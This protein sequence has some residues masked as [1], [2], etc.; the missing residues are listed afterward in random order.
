MI[1]LKL[2]YEI[3]NFSGLLEVSEKNLP[4]GN[5]KG[6]YFFYNQSKELL[7][8]GKSKNCIRQRLRKHLFLK[9]DRIED[10]EKYENRLTLAKR[11][12]YKY[13]SFCEIESDLVEIVEIFLIK[14]FKPIF[15]CEYNNVCNMPDVELTK[16][17]IEMDHKSNNIYLNL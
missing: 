5:T 9:F 12:Y 4:K 10:F 16:Y 6:C 2:E 8:V 11:E 14:K 17:E 3:D 1:G 7:Y 15:N 13:F